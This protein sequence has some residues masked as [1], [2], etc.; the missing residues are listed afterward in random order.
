[1]ALP[2]QNRIKR[3]GHRLSYSL[4]KAS[5]HRKWRGFARYQVALTPS[6]E[7]RVDVRMRA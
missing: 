4:H 6:D 3:I 5:R 1:M 7:G 2:Y